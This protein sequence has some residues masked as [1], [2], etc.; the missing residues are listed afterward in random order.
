MTAQAAQPAYM[1]TNSG[2]VLEMPKP[3]EGPT[4]A[5]QLAELSGTYQTTVCPAHVGHC[6]QSC[7]PPHGD[8]SSH[9]DCRS[10]GRDPAARGSR[11]GVAIPGSAT[12]AL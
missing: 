3:E 4:T 6:V 9:G 11:G 12:P 8:Q 2:R 10:H 1:K 7:L 5:E